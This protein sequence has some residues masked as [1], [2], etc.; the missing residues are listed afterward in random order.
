MGN[1]NSTMGYMGGV[2]WKSVESVRLKYIIQTCFLSDGVLHL[3]NILN[4]YS[5]VG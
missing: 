3:Q 1:T 2:S 5:L 4:F